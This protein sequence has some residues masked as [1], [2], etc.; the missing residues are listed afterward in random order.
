LEKI[1]KA[2]DECAVDLNYIKLKQKLNCFRFHYSDSIFAK[3]Q[4]G[5]IKRRF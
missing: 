4:T 3:L 2:F 5:R 1:S